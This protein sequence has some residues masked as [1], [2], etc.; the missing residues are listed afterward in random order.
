MKVFWDPPPGEV[1]VHG[2]KLT[3]AA[4]ALAPVIVMARAIPEAMRPCMPA[5]AAMID[6][7]F[8]FYHCNDLLLNEPVSLSSLTDYK[9]RIGVGGSSSLR[10]QRPPHFTCG[11]T[12][13]SSSSSSMV[14][15]LGCTHVVV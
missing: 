14:R 10:A 4:P 2:R 8:V 13:G 12:V 11:H 1:D 6:C 9:G 7:L 15:V 5:V 3:E